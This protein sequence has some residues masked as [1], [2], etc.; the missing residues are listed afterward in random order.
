MYKDTAVKH[1][2]AKMLVTVLAVELTEPAA[3]GG[4]CALAGTLALRAKS[5]MTASE[6]TA[7]RTEPAGKG[8]ACAL[9]GTLALRAKS[10]MT[11]SVS[12]AARTA[13]APWA[14]VYARRATRVRVVTATWTNALQLRVSTSRRAA[15]A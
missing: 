2:I 5:L 6:S 7:A 12:T 1:V 8:A 10:S 9:A 4:A 14:D 3:K 11:A 13:A 15:L